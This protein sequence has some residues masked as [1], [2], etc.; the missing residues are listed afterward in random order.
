MTGHQFRTIP[1]IFVENSDGKHSKVNVHDFLGFLKSDFNTTCPLETQAASKLILRGPWML[2]GAPGRPRNEMENNTKSEKRQV[3]TRF[4]WNSPQ[5]TLLCSSSFPFRLLMPA[6]TPRNG[7][8]DPIFPFSWPWPP[9]KRKRKN[10][11]PLATRHPPPPPARNLTETG[12]KTSSRPIIPGKQVMTSS[13]GSFRAPADGAP[14]MTNLW[15]FPIETLKPFSS[16]L[17]NQNRNQVR[18]L[19]SIYGSRFA[20]Y[21]FAP[22]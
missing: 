17:I 10:S 5:I 22:Q 12:K 20:S 19:H 9:P 8:V 13:S 21:H 11:F 7:K 1:Q 2:P 3:E 4:S 6:P 14:K 15:D 18:L 16:M